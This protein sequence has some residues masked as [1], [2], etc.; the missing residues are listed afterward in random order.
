[1][2]HGSQTEE[3]VL[4][5]CMI[6]IVT[7][8]SRHVCYVYLHKGEMIAN[9]DKVQVSNLLQLLNTMGPYIWFYVARLTGNEKANSQ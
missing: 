1:M 9:G 3:H 6:S 5:C 8:L 4:Y 2:S 7:A